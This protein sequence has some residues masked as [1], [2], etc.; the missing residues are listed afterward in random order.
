MQMP[1]GQSPPPV[2]HH[3][4]HDHPAMSS[5]RLK[6]AI[7]G[8]MRAYWAK[9]VDP[10]RVETPPTE[11]M[12]Q[13]SLVDV[14][15]TQPEKVAE[16]YAVL[17]VDAP[18]RPTARQLQEGKDS[19]PGTKIHTA[20][21]EAQEREKWWEQFAPS[22]QGREVIPRDWMERA[23]AIR[24]VLL[25]HPD[26]GPLLEDALVTSQDPHLWLDES[27]GQWC[28]Y[29]PDLET[30]GG[31]LWDLKKARSCSPRAMVAQSYA[32]GYD[33]QLVHYWEGYRNRHRARPEVAG[34][35]CYEWEWPH[36]SILMPA[37]PA[38]LDM[39]TERRREAAQRIADCTAS[40][41]WPSHPITPL[42]VPGWRKRGE[43]QPEESMPTPEP[44]ALF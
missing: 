29:L 11:A 22:I 39:G 15:I 43:A 25:Q 14:F 3:G 34:L 23:E 33:V 35:I 6:A 10:D 2:D 12:R 4:Y 9:H 28:R 24:G 17:P 41:E 38:L 30:D 44:I 16:R 37:E 8:T 7:T 31:G 1:Q 36:D 32:L 18:K 26:I 40:G 19:R 20:W 13:G 5:S 27:L 21:L 42:D